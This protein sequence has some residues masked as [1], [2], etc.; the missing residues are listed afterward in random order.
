MIKFKKANIEDCKQI[1]SMQ[2]QS[3][4]SLFTKYNDID[5]NPAAESIDRI[6]QRMNQDFTDYYLIKIEDKTIGAIRIVRLNNDIC[7]ISP[8]FILPEYQGN[9]YA[10]Q[11]IKDIELLYPQTRGWQLDTIKEEDKLCHL[12][13]KMGYKRTGKEEIIQKNMTIVY[14]TKSTSY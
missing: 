9:G 1:H 14:Y 8:M 2:V 5:T 3:F 4:Q 11:V 7:R 13:E 12:Y 10:Q 6:I